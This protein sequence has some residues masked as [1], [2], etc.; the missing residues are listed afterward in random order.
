MDTIRVKYDYKIDSENGNSTH[1]K[2]LGLIGF[3]KKILEIG[4][5]S[6]YMTEY[7]QNVL[8]CR[9]TGIELDEAAAARAQ[10]FCEK[11]I[12]ADVENLD[13]KGLFGDETFDVIIMA[14]V[15]EHLKDPESLLK[16]I[17]SYIAQD[18]FVLI[19]IPN[20]AHG[21]ISLNALDGNWNYRPMGL[22]DE[23]HL[24]FFDR[25]SFNRLLET[26]GFFISVIDRVIVHPRDTEFKTSWDT[27][28]R[29]VTAYIEKVNPE[30]QTYQFVIKA[31]PASM[32]GWKLGLE[33]CARFEK[34]RSHGLDDDLRKAKADL[35]K[36]HSSY[37]EEI[38][39]LN[40]E[41]ASLH[42]VYGKEIS[43]LK[44]TGL[45][46][47]GEINR[48]NEEIISIHGSYSKRLSELEESLPVIHGNYQSEIARLEAEISSYDSRVAEINESYSKTV[49]ELKNELLELD[50]NSNKGQE[51]YMDYISSLE[52]ERNNLSAQVLN[53]RSELEGIHNSLF[54]KIISRYRMIIESIL[55]PGT[56]RRR[57][58]QLSVLAPIVFFSEGP[59][60]FS[61]KFLSRVPVLKNYYRP[62]EPAISFNKMVFPVF[63]SIRVSIIIPVYN[64]CDYT[65]RCLLSIYENTSGVSYEVIVVDNASKDSTSAMLS[66]FENIVA[67]R[68][69]ENKGF[70]EACNIGAAKARGEYLLFLNNDTEVTQGWLEAMCQPFEN[71]ETGIVGA[72]LVYPDGSLQEAGNII[73]KD[74]S[75]WN[76][77]RGDDPKK[78]E[79]CYRKSVDYCSGACLQISRTLW[80]EI[81]GFDMRYAPAYYEDTD[82]CFEVR[83]RGY[84][85]IYQPEAVV[86]HYEGVSSGTDINKGYKKFQQINH[87]KFLD[88]WKTVL[89]TE[90]FSGP[91]FLFM[92]RE[93]CKG[94]R[95]LVADHYV[96]EFDKDS[97]SLRMFSL[98]KILNEMGHKVVFWP[99]NRAY[100]S[101]YTAALQKMGIETCYGSTHF[102]EYMKK[103]G[104]FFDYIILSR[105]HIAEVMI[106]AAR[107]YSKAKII[108]DTVDLHYV[109]EGR[110]VRQEAEK[111]ESEWKKRELGLA[112]QADYTLVVSSV[113][114]ELLEK[115]G[116]SSSISVV[117][118]IH[119]LEDASLDFEKRT[120]I[121]FI[122]GF[123]HTPNEDAMIWFVDEIWP[124]IKKRIDNAHFYIVGSHPSD[125]IK[126][127][128]A[129]DITVTGFVE[130]VTPY[131]TKSR[132]FVSPLRYGAGVKGKIG[133][134]LSYGLPVVTTHIGAEGM[135]LVDGE[136]SLIADDV[137]SFASKVIE[138]YNDSGLW[139]RLSEGGR[140]L[141]EKRFSPEIMKEN[142]LQLIS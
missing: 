72:K 9:V 37:S 115:E 96:P 105:P 16:K 49:N 60:S 38:K 103:N 94:K 53:L 18:G 39:R 111:A 14:D 138:L 51:R 87:S 116:I 128:A 83:N 66:S 8:N 21:S 137:E 43:D 24:R 114:K 3:N 1:S 95:I 124:V 57:F 5:S 52:A 139:C 133:Q 140:S 47:F 32:A 97:G 90:H 84:A 44:E 82:L 102:D 50:N 69:S 108:Y 119:S 78:P 107:N 65:L 7:M 25:D 117:T 26:S 141:I 31:Y 109:R 134:S 100:N 56:K 80:D 46:Q 123:M 110:R 81:G 41:A 10:E 13:F 92:A 12:V 63:D 142:L 6:G 17:N 88:K 129:S 36:I 93:R 15:L 99:E 71:Q 91:D 127:L 22:M 126:A 2:I 55:P 62:K 118:N 61:R 74:A 101:K 29:E 131:F 76:Y 89:E 120:G 75:G 45:K 20:G 54:W 42:E 77:G 67:V 59:S 28:P 125:K 79:Y 64:K 113:E 40:E 34:E 106:Y 85:V 73:W 33:E 132:V 19:S 35:D 112:N 58:Y 121:M 122:G 4:C 136:N 98:I 130:D 30:F 48:L 68:N 11:M 135:G 86:I 70:V 27:Y 23:T 104:S